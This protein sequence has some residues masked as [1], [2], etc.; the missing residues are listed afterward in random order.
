MK[1]GLSK[2]FLKVDHVTKHLFIFNLSTSFFLVL[3]NFLSHYLH[4]FWF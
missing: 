4:F 1:V 2:V 3:C